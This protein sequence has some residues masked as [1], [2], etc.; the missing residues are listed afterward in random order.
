M[1]KTVP[2]GVPVTPVGKLPLLR[3]MLVALEAV[4][5]IVVMAVPWY[6]DWLAAPPERAMVG[7]AFITPLVLLEYAL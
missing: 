2:D 4:Y 6:T 5:V 7:R 3:A 1:V